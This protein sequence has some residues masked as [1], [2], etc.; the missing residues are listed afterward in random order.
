MTI[1]SRFCNMFI[2]SGK[3]SLFQAHVCVHVHTDIHMYT[4]SADTRNVFGVW[5]KE[6]M[7]CAC[8]SY[9]IFFNPTV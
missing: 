2:M 9:N 7:L 6:N 1:A 5:V 8:I 3:K 4:Q